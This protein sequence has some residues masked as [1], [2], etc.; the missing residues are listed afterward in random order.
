MNFGDWAGAV[1][2][3]VQI[4]ALV[5]G[6]AWAYYKFIR[7]R[8][9]HRRAEMSLTAS[10][11][12][13][14]SQRSLQIKP[15]L[16]NTG[17]ADIPFRVK[18]IKVKSFREG[19]LDAKGRALWSDV[20]V[21]PVFGDHDW[22]ESQET[23]SDDVLIPLDAYSATEDALAYRVSCVIY[24]QR[25]KRRLRLDKGGG[26]CWTAN[27]IVP[28]GLK[29]LDMGD[30]SSDDERRT[31]EERKPARKDE[32]EHAA[33]T[34]NIG[35]EQGG[36]IANVGGD[37]FR[38]REEVS[39]EKKWSTPWKLFQRKAPEDEIQDVEHATE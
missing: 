3:I 33:V 8:T 10:L 27:A 16:K 6:T 35:H 7:G 25:R 15:I 30:A 23:I 32:T 29:T 12:V 37:A 13:T 17:G 31:M 21:A 9:F 24:E 38:E 11:L 14:D 18:V 34:F 4:A 20:T 22:I 5:L 39:G 1:Q 36:Q 2:S 28:A 26:I 19:D